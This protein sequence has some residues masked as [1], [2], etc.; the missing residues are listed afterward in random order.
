MPQVS[1]TLLDNIAGNFGKAARESIEQL[2]A[3]GMFFF[4]TLAAL[5]STLTKF[6]LV[7]EQMLRMGVYSL[8]IVFL[9]SAF[10]GL[11]SAWQYHYIASD[12][13]PLT[14]LGA[15]MGKVI[16]TDLG[17]V[18][19]ALVLTGRIGARLAA[20]LGTMKVTEQIDAMTCLS[21]N[22]CHYLLT[23]RIIA[24]FLMTPALMV[25]SFFF[26]IV[27]AQMLSLIAFDMNPGSFYNS[28]RLLFKFNDVIIGIVKGFVF[29]GG[30][31]L[32]GCYYGF[33]AAGGAVGVGESTKRAVV[34]SAIL[35]LFTNLIV[36]FILM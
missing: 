24:G 34:A 10:I 19:T 33:F 13:I 12:I 11:V 9:T 25:F 26:S 30:I 16:F 15:A 1:G 18:L 21:L 29:G 31:A 17:P 23:P 6:H 2:G 8:P 7:T 36:N 22:P 35:I 20:E 5:P 3:I 4:G 14:Y 32:A 27:S 28:L